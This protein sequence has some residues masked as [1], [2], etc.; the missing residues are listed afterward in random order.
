MGIS[1]T[2]FVI[3]EEGIIV[4]IITNVKTKG[5]TRQILK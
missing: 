3:D 5:H 2:T 4:D 1:R